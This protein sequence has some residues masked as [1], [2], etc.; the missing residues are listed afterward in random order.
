M[1]L[2]SLTKELMMKKETWTL[3]EQTFFN[4]VEAKRG[5]GSRIMMQRIFVHMDAELKKYYIDSTIGE[6][7]DVRPQNNNTEKENTDT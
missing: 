4:F 7:N 6:D 2:T 5:R 1:M 3:D